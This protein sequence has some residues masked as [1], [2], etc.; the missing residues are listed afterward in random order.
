MHS[1]NASLAVGPI[2]PGILKRYTDDGSPVVNGMNGANG[3]AN[4]K[5]RF[6]KHRTTDSQQVRDAEEFELEGLITDEEDG[7]GLGISKKSLNGL[8]TSREAV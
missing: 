1:R 6:P 2:R 3:N 5:T 8:N 7:D 4:G